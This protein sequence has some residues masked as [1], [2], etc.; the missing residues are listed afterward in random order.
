M[1]LKNLQ[2]RCLYCVYGTPFSFKF[3]MFGQNFFL[4]I[5]LESLLSPVLQNEQITN[6]TRMKDAQMD[7][8]V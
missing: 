2:Q 6:T 5:C 3:R 8:I 1:V 4:S 7:T